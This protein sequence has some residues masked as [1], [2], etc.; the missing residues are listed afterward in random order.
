MAV[1]PFVPESCWLVLILSAISLQKA[2]FRARQSGSGSRP[3]A[4]STF[5]G[6]EFDE[7]F[8]LQRSHRFHETS[9][10]DVH[11]FPDRREGILSIDARQQRPF[12]GAELERLGDRELVAPERDEIERVVFLIRRIVETQNANGDEAEHDASGFEDIGLEH[13]DD[14]SDRSSTVH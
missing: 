10:C 6:G 4:S 11:D 13:V 14:V 7:A 1:P 3:F 9:R 12:P 8:V 5:A 2:K